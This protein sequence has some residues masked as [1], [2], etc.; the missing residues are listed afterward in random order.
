MNPHRDEIV[1]LRGQ[2][3]TFGQIAERLGLSRGAV[4]GVVYR[5]ASPTPP[6]QPRVLRGVN[7][8]NCRLSEEEVREIKVRLGRGV[9]GSAL[10]REYDV[11]PGLISMIKHGKRWSHVE[12]A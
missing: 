5:A 10:A 12:A 4:S 6:R 11:D 8:P 9:V 1:S 3:F 2:G 7:N